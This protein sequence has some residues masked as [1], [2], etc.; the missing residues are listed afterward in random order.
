MSEKLDEILNFGLKM[1]KYKVNN[2]CIVIA[3][4]CRKEPKK[5]KKCPLKILSRECH[6]QSHNICHSGLLPVTGKTT[7]SNYSRTRHSGES[8]GT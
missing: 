6:H 4:V 3:Y 8:P 7:D 5:K 1:R 2:C